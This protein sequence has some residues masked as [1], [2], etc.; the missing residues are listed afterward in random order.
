MDMHAT[1]PFPQTLHNCAPVHR[2]AVTPHDSPAEVLC[3]P[4]HTNTRSRAPR[5]STH[6]APG[7]TMIEESKSG[8]IIAPHNG[9][10]ASAAS[11]AASTFQAGPARASSSH[12]A[13]KRGSWCC[14]GTFTGARGCRRRGGSRRARA[15][16]AGA[17]RPSCRRAAFSCPCT[18]C[19]TTRPRSCG[20][21]GRP[22][23]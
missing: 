20:T 10:S 22:A 6:P 18:S 16:R 7:E 11:S 9:H 2:W 19:R 17:C 1:R 14:V 23:T 4:A 13:S 21:C 15:S 12:G 8:E 5:V 3:P